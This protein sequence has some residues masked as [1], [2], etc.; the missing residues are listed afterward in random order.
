MSEFANFIPHPLCHSET[1]KEQEIYLEQMKRSWETIE[2]YLKNSPSPNWSAYHLLM[3]MARGLPNH[4]N[5]LRDLAEK[6]NA[7]KTN[8]EP[9]NDNDISG[10]V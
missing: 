3:S 6:I 7:R 8:K 9:E 5:D 10:S 1:L 4:Y 2:S